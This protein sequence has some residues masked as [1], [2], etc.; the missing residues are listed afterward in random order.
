MPFARRQGSPRTARL[1]G[2]CF[3]PL[4]PQLLV[5]ATCTVTHGGGGPR[6]C[7]GLGWWWRLGWRA[8]PPTT[9]T[10]PTVTH[11]GLHDASVSAWWL[12]VARQGAAGGAAS[13]AHPPP[14]FTGQKDPWPGGEEA[15]GRHAQSAA[16]AGAGA[17]HAV[18]MATAGHVAGQGQGQGWTRLPSCT[19]PMYGPPPGLYA[20]RKASSVSGTEAEGQAQ[21]SGAKRSGEGQ[22]G[23]AGLG[24][25]LPQSRDQPSAHPY[26]GTVPDPDM[27]AARCVDSWCRGRTCRS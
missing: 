19:Q 11:G 4:H 20:R 26:I 16:T 13:G 27:S 22:V 17:L 12:R 18:H 24:G 2:V 1:G 7:W 23:G 6:L 15:S 21:G 14:T 8:P 5:Q 3:V 10:T 9:A 25:A